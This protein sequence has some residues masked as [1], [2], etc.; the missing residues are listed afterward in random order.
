VAVAGRIKLQGRVFS[1]RTAGARSV[2]LLLPVAYVVVFLLLPLVLTLVWSLWEREGFW[3]RPALTFDSYL[4]FFGGPRA[5]VLVRTAILAMIVTVVGLLLAYPVA[6][7][8]GMRLAPSLGRAVLLLF[9]I[10]FVV[11]YILRDVSWTYLLTRDGPVNTALLRLSLIHQPL[12]WL[13]FSHFAVLVGLITSYMPFMIYPI[14]LALT[15]IDRRLLETSW[16]LGAR[17]S[18]T[19][20][21]V[22]LPLSLPGVFAG[23]M[24]AFV[25]SFGDSAVARI[26]GGSGYQMM[27]NTITSALGVLNYPLAAAMSTVVVAMMILLL[28]I[29]FRLFDARSLL[30][31]VANW[32][33]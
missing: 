12:D 3:M 18:T 11:N 22:T 24:F 8:I 32:R 29:W 2:L 25:G 31:R 5:T 4:T 33:R 26:L 21:R 17:P 23:L 19:F 15:G 6:Y 28:S 14:W 27:G 9:T 7:L 13:L 10:P 30:G 1:L 20:L 16:L